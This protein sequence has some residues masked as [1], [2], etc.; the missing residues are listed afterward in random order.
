MTST[1]EV[2]PPAYPQQGL[3]SSLSYDSST[4]KLLR[5]DGQTHLPSQPWMSLNSDELTVQL[6][7]AHQVSTIEV[8]RRLI[9]VDSFT[10]DSI[11]SPLPPLH[12]LTT[13]NEY[14]LKTATHPDLHLT[15]TT[16][17][18][19]QLYI[20][21]LPIYFLSTAFW[22]WLKCNSG[23][24][25]NHDLYIS[26]CGFMRTYAALIRS[27]T[28]FNIAVSQEA[29]LI[30]AQNSEGRAV[31]FE[32]FVGFLKDAGFDQMQNSDVSPRWR[33]G[34][35]TIGNPSK[36]QE[37]YT[38]GCVVADP[39]IVFWIRLVQFGLCAG[40]I[41]SQ[42]FIYRSL[43]KDDVGGGAAR[44]FISFA[45]LL[46]SLFVASIVKA[47]ARKSARTRV[48]EQTQD[49]K[50]QVKDADVEKGLSQGV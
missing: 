42:C 23:P 27:E 1:S 22:D 32:S 18:P 10:E 34:I 8:L 7:K 35:L 16:T 50:K 15:R 30:P 9:T 12:V 24:E 13:I 11:A 46:F 48:G 2:D 39:R 5:L 43:K 25:S 31:T 45:V 33:H 28:D 36:I 21:P 44:F 37:L 38:Y 17:T 4:R 26:A 40:W 41:V 3:E 49:G 29:G 20:Q 6:R 47:Q 19:V 14:A